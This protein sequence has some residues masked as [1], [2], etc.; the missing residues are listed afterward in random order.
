MAAVVE[1]IGLLERTPL[2]KEALEVRYLFQDCL[3]QTRNRIIMSNLEFFNLFSFLFTFFCYHSSVWLNTIFAGDWGLFHV[4]NFT[5]H[6]PVRYS[7]TVHKVLR[8]KFQKTKV[9]AINL[10][11][12]FKLL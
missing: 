8:D 12:I 6:F 9:I 3:W 7:V 10:L 11:N 4:D 1:V 2:T 5:L